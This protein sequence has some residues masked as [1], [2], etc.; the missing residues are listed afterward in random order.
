MNFTVTYDNHTVSARV[1]ECID[2]VARTLSFDLAAN[3][4]II[5]NEA[6][7]NAIAA[8][9]RAGET[10]ITVSWFQCQDTVRLEIEDRGG[11]FEY[12]HYLPRPM[13]AP[14]ATHGRGIPMMKRLCTELVY[15][16]TEKGVRLYAIWRM[17]SG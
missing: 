11:G 8:N 9:E 7:A 12:Q 10:E 14:D 2:L 15:L 17:E 4:H 16:T 5:F 6:V 1:R 3:V 13:P